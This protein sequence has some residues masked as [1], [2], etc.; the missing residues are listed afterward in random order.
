MYCPE[1]LVIQNRLVTI[2]MIGSADIPKRDVP[3]SWW[4]NPLRYQI[5]VWKPRYWMINRDGKYRIIFANFV[6]RV[7]QRI[8]GKSWR[9]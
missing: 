8:K 4:L 2:Y 3:L 6:Y 9:T 5:V 1:Q 7:K